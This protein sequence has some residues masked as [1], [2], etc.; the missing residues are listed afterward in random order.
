M[1]REEPAP[2]RSTEPLGR[3]TGASF[4]VWPDTYPDN[5]RSSQFR[6][7]FELPQMEPRG[8]RGRGDRN[9]GSRFLRGTQA[10]LAVAITTLLCAEC[11]FSK[12]AAEVA[13]AQ[14][15]GAELLRRESSVAFSLCR[16]EALL[17]YFE[18]S[19]GKITGD[20]VPP[21]LSFEEFWVQKPAKRDIHGAQIPWAGYCGELD[22]TGEIFHAAVLAL[23][24]YAR[25]IAELTDATHVS[26]GRV[27]SVPVA[28]CASWS[29][30]RRSSHRGGSARRRWSRRRRHLAPRR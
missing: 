14:Q 20:I 30:D 21:P 3:P 27:A 22:K 7:I 23:G 9:V 17:A 19:L 16:Q 2:C 26:E 24:D 8:S 10:V 13:H 1:F 29:W 4:V 28:R 18:A 25:G 15:A 6:V 11:S 5:G 12:T